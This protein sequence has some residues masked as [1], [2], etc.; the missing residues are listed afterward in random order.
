M[1]K[2]PG[3]KIKELLKVGG[4]FMEGCV[5]YIDKVQCMLFDKIACV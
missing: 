5:Y 2:I 4:I 1:V 3:F